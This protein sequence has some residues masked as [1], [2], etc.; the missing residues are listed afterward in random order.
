MELKMNFK[1]IIGVIVVLSNAINAS[2]AGFQSLTS[3]GFF[4][5][6]TFIAGSGITITNGDGTSGNPTI[7]SFTPNSVVS[8]SDDFIGAE[9]ANNADLIS[10]LTWFNSNGGL[11]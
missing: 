11:G 7:S 5:G 4:H 9:F 3:G 8:I 6:R 2:E 1:I 10:Q